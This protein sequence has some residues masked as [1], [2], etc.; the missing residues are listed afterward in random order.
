MLNQ[1]H[2]LVQSRL[3]PPMVVSPPVSNK[4]SRIVKRADHKVPVIQAQDNRRKTTVPKAFNTTCFLRQNQRT[5]K[6]STWPSQRWTAHLNLNRFKRNLEMYLQEAP[7]GNMQ[8]LWNRLTQDRS[9]MWSHCIHP[10]IA[11]E[12]KLRPLCTCIKR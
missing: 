6:I 11:K 12:H 8:P 5:A 1:A 2:D 10:R 3:H 7:V 4:K 9:T